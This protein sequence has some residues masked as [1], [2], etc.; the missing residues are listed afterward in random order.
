[1]A[2]EISECLRE[3]TNLRD[4]ITELTNQMKGMCTCEA[5][6]EHHSP[7][8]WVERKPDVPVHIA[9][10]FTLGQEYPIY[11]IHHELILKAG[12]DQRAERELF[13]VLVDKDGDLTRCK[14]EDFTFA[15]D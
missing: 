7:L 14:A 13:V 1:M 4:I 6:K 5:P 9:E 10:R 3:N 12:P 11:N 15:R 2:K 8:L